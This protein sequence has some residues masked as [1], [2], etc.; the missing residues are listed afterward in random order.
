VSKQIAMEG[1]PHNIRC[2]TISPGLVL[3]EADPAF[4]LRR[5]WFARMKAKLMLGREA[6]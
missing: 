2:N 3:T 4:M 5:K 6:A 1:G